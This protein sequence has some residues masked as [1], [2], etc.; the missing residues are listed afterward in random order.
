MIIA[1]PQWA[2]VDAPTECDKKEHNVS[3]KWKHHTRV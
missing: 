2:L 1:F 3:V